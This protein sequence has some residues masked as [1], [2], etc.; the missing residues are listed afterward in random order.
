MIHPH[1]LVDPSARIA[2]DVH[3]GAFSVIGPEVEIGFGT[4]VGPHVVINGPARIG[5]DNRIYQFSSLGEVPQD[6]K[7][8][9]EH[10]SLE[11]GDRNIIREYCTM[12]RGTVGGGSVTRIGCDNLFMA[13]VHIAHDCHVGNH[14]IFANCASL[15][16][17]VTVEDY[18]VLGGFTGMHQ[19]CRLGAHAM[20]AIG[21]VSFKDVPPFIMASGN[22]ARPHG[23]NLTGLKRRGFSAEAISALRKAYRLT[24]RSGLRLEEAIEQLQQMRECREVAVFADFIGATERGII[25]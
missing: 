24:Y 15:A 3:I 4:W 11:I 9:G 8:R 6:L 13:Y 16:G 18:A 23:I 25:R 14:T 2:E 22:T 19:F 7:Y 12:S 21:T 5:S 1:A 10:S 17:H 20:T